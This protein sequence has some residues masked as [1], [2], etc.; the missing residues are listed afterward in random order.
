LTRTIGAPVEHLDLATVIKMS[1]V[2]SVEIVLEK[3]LDTLM[4]A[5]IAQAGA[6]RVLL[7]L[8]RGAAQR[9][10]A[11]ATTSGDTVTVSSTRPWPRGIVR[12]RGRSRK[13]AR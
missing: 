1:Q 11:R 4:R 5:V 3:L 9:I 6:E 8:A 12:L 7:I 13:M 2:V 10:V